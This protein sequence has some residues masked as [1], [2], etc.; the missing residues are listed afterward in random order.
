[1]QTGFTPIVVADDVHARYVAWNGLARQ[2]R[3]AIVE[4]F[5]Y[6][7]HVLALRAVLVDDD[8]VRLAAMLSARTHQFVPEA[9]YVFVYDGAEGPTRRMTFEA[10]AERM[11]VLKGEP[12]PFCFAA[13]EDY[14]DEDFGDEDVWGHYVTPMETRWVPAELAHPTGE[15]EPFKFIGFDSVFSDEDVARA[16]A[17]L[18]E[19]GEAPTESQSA[20]D[21]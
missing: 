6:D 11:P 1:M 5:D 16:Q 19:S 17:I 18:E 10:V 4:H 8:E 9:D 13:Y 20:L 12:T 14:D 3:A 2:R 15:D 7:V 21:A